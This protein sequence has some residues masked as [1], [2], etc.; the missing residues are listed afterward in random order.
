[1]NTMSPF[2]DEA[3]PGETAA[4]IEPEQYL[5][6]PWAGEESLE[7]P[8]RWFEEEDE[9]PPIPASRLEWPGAS[10]EKLAFMQAVYQRHFDNSV[11]SGRPYVADLKPDQLDVIDGSFRGRTDAAGAARDLLVTARA[12]LAAA[13]LGGKVRIGVVS[14]YRDAEYQFGIWEGKGKNE[15]GGFP[16]YYRQAVK[17][18]VI[19]EGDYGADAVA[20]MA[21]YIGQYIA[22]P[23]FSNHQDGLAIDFGTGSVGK[24]DFGA[25]GGASWFH[26]WLVDNATRFNYHPYV[27]ET[28]HWVYRPPASA[29]ESEHS[30]DY[31]TPKIVVPAKRI[32]VDKVPLLRVHRGKTPDLVL[33]WND[34]TAVPTEIDV[35][36]HLHG[37]WY[38]T[39]ALRTNI[40]PV[41]GLD[42]APPSGAT[43][44]GRVRPT[45]TVLPRGHDSGTKQKDGDY[46][47][48]Q[49][50][51]I[52]SKDGFDKLLKFAL[53]RFASEVGGTAPAISR[54][55]LTAH[56]GGAAALAA[57]L[58]H[59]DAHQ[60]HI[61]DGLYG[62]PDQL[63][64]WV[65]ERIRRDA[66][67][68]KGMTAAQCRTYQETKGGALRVFYQGKKKGGTRP[69]SLQLRG[70]LA[71]DLN[72]EL[73]PWYRVEASAYDHFGIP[74]TYGW[75][76]LTDV[77]VDVPDAYL[78]HAVKA[79]AVA[80]GSHELETYVEPEYGEE[81]WAAEF[82]DEDEADDEDYAVEGLFTQDD[83]ENKL[84]QLTE[85]PWGEHDM[86]VVEGDTPADAPPAPS[87]GGGH[88]KWV[89]LV[90]GFDYERSGVDFQSIAMHRLERLLR[91][92]AAASKTA[93]LTPAQMADTAPRFIVVDVKSGTIRKRL[94]DSNGKW[95]WT[96]VASFDPVSSANYTPIPGSPRHVFDRNQA[97]RMSIMDIHA[98]VRELGRTEPGSLA[99]LSFFSHGWVGG[100]LLVN[101][102]EGAAFKG[103]PDRDP[104]DKDPRM[105]KDFTGA[106]MDATGRAEFR[107]AF[108]TDGFMWAWGCAFA[109]APRQVLHQV[110]NS[111]KYR[112]NKLGELKDEDTFHFDFSRAHAEQFFEK[113]PSFFPAR[114]ADGTFP[115]KFERTFAEIKAFFVSMVN[116]TYFH[117]LALV[118][119]VPCFAALPGTYADYEKGV[120]LPLMVVPTKV[121]PYSDNFLRSIQFYTTYFG[122][123]LDPEDRHYGRYDP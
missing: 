38:P 50:P 80:P 111:R 97:G 71:D 113:I 34:M 89:M 48:Y 20:K 70:L 88:G 37:F 74:K 23:G 98:H 85:S 96:D 95:A 10:D 40:E 61:F 43:G 106:Q 101:S 55:I 82:E 87:G 16:Y 56:S 47:I 64:D 94:M 84:L 9:T 36:V 39:L 90:A 51:A 99:E 78:E 25:I 49:F 103:Q 11:Q 105:V 58:A 32:A 4:L 31:D 59:H 53:D 41:S 112:T 122:L 44:V 86:L 21:R 5:E 45:L 35:V 92:H 123:A 79:A 109:N 75:R 117:L 57:I 72:A 12:D 14:A 65:G 119:N 60:V 66:A 107:A 2:R 15:K 54:L 17:A 121:P 19:G 100:P 83:L 63:V 24:D 13:G 33:G 6:Q 67:A 76:L 81:Q 68:V 104:D 69:S 29:K 22:A 18:G 46:N 28:W 30:Y 8:A 1:M 110:L 91:K 115:L 77:S 3:P 93:K 52:V 118:A 114:N 42:V 27:K 26:H 120:S 116:N 73:K 62:L 102:D 7:E 108:D